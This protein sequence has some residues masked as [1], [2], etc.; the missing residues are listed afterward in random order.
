M[1]GEVVAL[2]AAIS[3]TIEQLGREIATTLVAVSA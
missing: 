2:V 1:I 3:Q